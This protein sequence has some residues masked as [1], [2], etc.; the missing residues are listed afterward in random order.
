MWFATYFASQKD[1]TY[2]S[3]LVKTAY[4]TKS[5]LGKKANFFFI[6]CTATVTEYFKRKVKLSSNVKFAFVVLSNCMDGTSSVV[7]IRF[8][9]D[10]TKKIRA[11][12]TVLTFSVRSL[13]ILSLAAVHIVKS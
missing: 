13:R 1:E 8:S 3:S 2:L 4:V 5:N 9:L 10:L 11:L 7:L 6:L 12:V